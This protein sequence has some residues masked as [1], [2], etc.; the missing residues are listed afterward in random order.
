MK[1]LSRPLMTI[2]TTFGPDKATIALGTRYKNG[3]LWTFESR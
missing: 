3:L 2:D 1:V